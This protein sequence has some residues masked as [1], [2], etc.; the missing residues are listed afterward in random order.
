VPTIV[1]SAVSVRMA[2]S[3]HMGM[4]IR[5]GCRC[6]ERREGRAV[7]RQILAWAVAFRRIRHRCLTPL[8]TN[9]LGH[10]FI[11]FLYPATK[12]SS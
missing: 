3:A 12:E 1:R 2:D 11:D 7:V 8:P 4:R 5:R 6:A 10:P 9:Q